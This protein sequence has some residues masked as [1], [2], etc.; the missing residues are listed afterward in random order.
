MPGIDLHR[1]YPHLVTPAQAELL[2]SLQT[3]EILLRPRQT[4][5]RPGERVSRAT[6][7]IDGF[8]GRFRA[9]AQ[10]RRQFLGLQ[11]PG[12]FIDLPALMLGH[13]DHEAVTFD[14]ARVACLPHA[15]IAG[16]RQAAPDVYDRLWHV[17]MLDAAIQR[18]W[19]FRASRLPGRARIASLF[20]ETL[21]RQYAR[22]LSGLGSCALP[23]SQTDLA[24][25]CG[26][27]PVHASRMLTELRQGGVCLFL[28]GR[29]EVL[30]LPALFR[31]AAFCWDYLYLPAGIDAELARVAKGGQPARHG[32]AVREARV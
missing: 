19:T 1:A 22:G 4:V 6:Y 29:I 30:D 17:S 12:D 11:I 25:A 20:A 27:T 21:V 9:D 16:L 28:D 3:D 32:P 24:E 10:G 15:R 8:V 14:A 26:M 31:Q 2:T 7:L 5:V 23:I 18:Y 13:L